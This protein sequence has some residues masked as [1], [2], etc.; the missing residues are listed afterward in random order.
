[1]LVF[2]IKNMEIR[3]CNDAGRLIRPLLKVKD[4]KILLTKEI[5]QDIKTK[6]TTWS[7]LITKNKYSH[8]IIEYIDPEEQN[9]SLIAID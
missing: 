1:M 6:K 9:H 7:D 8:S 3:I 5:M 2:D 4:K